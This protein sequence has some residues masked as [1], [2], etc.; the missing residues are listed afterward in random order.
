VQIAVADNGP[1]IPSED[2]DKVFDTFYSV[3]RGDSAGGPGLGLT[4]S[5]GIVEA[6]GGRIW[7]EKRPDG[8]TILT[9][10]LP[11]I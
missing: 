1:G 3:Q 9:L 4:V 6:H 5:R 2:L 11:I 8:G 7:A 10:S